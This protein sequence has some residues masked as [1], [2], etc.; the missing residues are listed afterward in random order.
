MRDLT[1]SKWFRA[2]LVLV[3]ALMVIQ[4]GSDEGCTNCGG[5]GPSEPQCTNED[6]TAGLYSFTPVS[7]ED[8]CDDM[9]RLFQEFRLIPEGPYAIQLPGYGDLPQATTITL[10]LPG[11]PLVPGTLDEVAGDIVFSPLGPVQVF[12]NLD[13]PHIPEWLPD[14]VSFDVAIGG[15][16]CPISETRVDAELAVSVLQAV[17]PFTETVCN[18]ESILRGNR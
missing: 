3:P 12:V 6:L 15:T 8:D 14:S 7:H 13:L 4:C 17:P 18:I 11:S 9:F 2:M 10:P 1:R 16:L 5:S